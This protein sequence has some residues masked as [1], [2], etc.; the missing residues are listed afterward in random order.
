MCLYGIILRAEIVRL[1]GEGSRR[2]LKSSHCLVRVVTCRLPS[3]D[4]RYRSVI[5]GLPVA[6]LEVLGVVGVC[7]WDRGDLDSFFLF[8]PFCRKYGS[9]YIIR[10]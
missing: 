8:F 10:P 3:A 1:R 2:R 4:R 9:A 6:G 5:G 7:V